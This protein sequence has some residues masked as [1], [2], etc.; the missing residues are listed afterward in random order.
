MKKIKIWL[1]INPI[2]DS[3]NLFNGQETEVEVPYGITIQELLQELEM[4]T[5][6][7]LIIING[8]VAE[9]SSKVYQGDH[10]YILPHLDGG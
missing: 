1:K 4:S 9:Y 8:S 3:Q 6:G 5:T 2:I 10:I 7:I